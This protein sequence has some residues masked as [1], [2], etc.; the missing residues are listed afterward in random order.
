MQSTA[1]AIIFH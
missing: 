1:H